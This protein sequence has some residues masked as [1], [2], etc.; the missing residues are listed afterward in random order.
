[1]SFEKL[2]DRKDKTQRDDRR[3][4]VY[5]RCIYGKGGFHCCRV[6]QLHNWNLYSVQIVT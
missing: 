4:L 3:F 6:R 1:M 5:V 2:T